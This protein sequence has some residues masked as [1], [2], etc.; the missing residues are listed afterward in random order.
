MT[1]VKVI[2]ELIKKGWTDRTDYIYNVNVPLLEAHEEYK[3]TMV[4]KQSNWGYRSLYSR[5]VED[6][7]IFDAEFDKVDGK[8]DT[9]TDKCLFDGWV[10]ISALRPMLEEVK[11]DILI[12]L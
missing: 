10:T 1:T 3:G 2:E 9:E 5:G 7:I 12:D 11:V 8:G 6:E 4:T